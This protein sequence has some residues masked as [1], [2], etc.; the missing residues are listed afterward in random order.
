MS[1]PR[2]CVMDN[3]SVYMC[4]VYRS[5]QNTAGERARKQQMVQEAEQELKDLQSELTDLTTLKSD[6]ENVIRGNADRKRQVE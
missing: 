4:V 2:V 1:V 6:M 5:Q 3:M